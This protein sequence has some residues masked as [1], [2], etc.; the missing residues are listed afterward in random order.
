MTDNIPNGIYGVFSADEA[1]RLEDW[2]LA[3]DLI[4]KGCFDLEPLI[5]LLA[6]KGRLDLIE[7]YIAKCGQK[8]ESDDADF[9]GESAVEGRQ[10]E[11]VEEMLKRGADR[12]QLQKSLAK[13][14]KRDLE[15]LEATRRIKKLLE[16]ST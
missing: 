13:R 4:N 10:L 11:L 16:E 6:R 14:E 2:D 15:K 1:I 9:V 5:V 12:K 8:W 7:K 3:D